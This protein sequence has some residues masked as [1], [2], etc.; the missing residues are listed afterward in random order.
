MATPTAT[1]AQGPKIPKVVRVLLVAVAGVVA[2][3]VVIVMAAWFLMPRDWIDKEA[4]KVAAGIP[5]ATLRWERLEPGLSGL[6]LGVRIRGLYWRQPAEGQGDARVEASVREVFVR[7]KLLP[8]LTRRVEVAA[9]RVS[10]A[11]VAMTDRGPLPPESTAAAGGPSGSGMALVLPRLEL[12][13]IDV[14]TRDLLGGG[15]DKRFGASRYRTGQARGAANRDDQITAA[16]AHVQHHLGLGRITSNQRSCERQV[17]G[18]KSNHLQTDRLKHIEALL[19]QTDRFKRLA[20]A[21]S[22]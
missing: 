5:G 6:S 4:R 11:G 10:G 1:P 14:R 15:T 16:A 3:L 18:F 17:V 2:L 20:Q 22:A 19:A 21:A 7:F 12:D 8:L 13:Q 9:A